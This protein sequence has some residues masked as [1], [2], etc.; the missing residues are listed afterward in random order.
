MRKNDYLKLMNNNES[1]RLQRR[2]APTEID[3]FN[4]VGG[5]RVPEL[6]LSA[7]GLA[8][9]DV[10][11]QPPSIYAHQPLAPGSPTSER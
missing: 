3:S 8:V 10:L 2:S 4:R 9:P 6:P 7:A 5:L 1:N 11:E